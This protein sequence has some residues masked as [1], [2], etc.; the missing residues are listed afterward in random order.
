[1]YGCDDPL[2]G[3]PLPGQTRCR[4]DENPEAAR[5]QETPRCARSPDTLI[6]NGETAAR[7]RLTG[8]TR[9]AARRTGSTEVRLPFFLRRLL[10]QGIGC[11]ARSPTTVVHCRTDQRV[12]SPW[13][14]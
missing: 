10:F 5:C 6:M 3:C 9:A 12:T 4:V 2:S 8:R 1:V 7:S 11:S 14:T 13:R